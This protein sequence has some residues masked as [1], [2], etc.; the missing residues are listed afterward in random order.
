MVKLLDGKVVAA[1]I[2]EEI[3]QEIEQMPG[4]FLPEPCLAVLLV[5]DDPASNI[6]VKKKMEV[7]EE[8]G[9]KSFLCQTKNMSQKNIIDIIKEWNDDKD[10]DGILVQLPLPK[11]INTQEI[12]KAVSP[13]KDVD[14]FHPENVGR[15]LI[16]CPR[17]LPCTPAGVQ[18][19]LWRNDI[20]TVGKKVLIIN[21][22]NIVGKP[23]A[24]MLVQDNEKANATVT[25]C[26]DKTPPE[27][28]KEVSLNSDI[29]MVAV[30]IPKFLTE[31]MIRP[32]QVVVDI[33]INRVNSKV[34]GDVDFDPVSEKLGDHG[35]ITPVPG[36][37]GPTTVACLMKN[38]L[39]AFRGV[40]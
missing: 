11:D 27:T 32:G 30:G 35:A 31:D 3:I 36:G 9:F 1:A 12:V 16:G 25:I 20:P 18:E 2:K 10:I 24:A 26:H 5:G 34:C 7:C 21:R 33:G 29:I 15:L 22:S 37:V 6:Y 39:K 23:L 19:L 38:V 13:L 28:L 4:R 14:V 8:I 17:F 40:I